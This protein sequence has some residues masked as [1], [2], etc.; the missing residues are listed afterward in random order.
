MRLETLVRLFCC[1]CSVGCVSTTTSSCALR[2][3]RVGEGGREGRKRVARLGAAGRGGGS[4]GDS[5]GHRKRDDWSWLIII[6]K[7]RMCVCSATARFRLDVAS[8]VDLHS[9]RWICGTRRGP[10]A[11]LDFG[12]H[13][14]ERL[15]HVGSIFRRRLQERNAQLIRQF[16][17]RGGVDAFLRLQ[18]TLV[19]NQQFVHVVAS[20]ALDLLQPLFHVLERIV[21]GA[22][23]H[24]DDAMC[25]A[26]VG[27]RYRTEAFLT[28]S[29]PDLQLDRLSVQIYGSNFKIHSNCADVTFRVRIVSK[30]EQQT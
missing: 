3:L 23:V 5:G 14:H 18:I 29:I 22:I 26:I 13:G 12:R 10:D 17:C 20:V 28:G 6:I 24:D 25:T 7:C 16:R 27:R 4:D 11:I 1:C 8:L 15:L 2:L 30:S 9:T 21:V 19:A